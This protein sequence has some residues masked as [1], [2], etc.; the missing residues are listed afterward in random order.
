MALVV[1]GISRR[2]SST[3]YSPILKDAPHGARIDWARVG[4]VAFILVAA[5]ATN[6]VVNLKFP[7]ALDQLPV[8]RRRGLGGASS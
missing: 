2:R 7:A 8:H 4:I 1:F 6:V 5:I 3:R